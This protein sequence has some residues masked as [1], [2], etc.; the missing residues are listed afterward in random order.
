M[1]KNGDLSINR[2][3]YDEDVAP[4]ICSVWRDSLDLDVVLLIQ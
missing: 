1:Q 4:K 3:T 2:T